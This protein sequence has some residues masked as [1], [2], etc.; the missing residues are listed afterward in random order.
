MENRPESEHPP[1]P[2]ETKRQAPWGALST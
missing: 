2:Q 1:K